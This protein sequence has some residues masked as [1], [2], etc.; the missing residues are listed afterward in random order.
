MTFSTAP[1]KLI[2]K[3]VVKVNDLID[4]SPLAAGILEDICVKK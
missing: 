1:M 3:G 2:K 4:Q